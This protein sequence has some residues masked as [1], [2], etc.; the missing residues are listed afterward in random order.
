MEESSIN[1]IV[2]IKGNSMEPLINDGAITFCTVMKCYS[3][4]DIIVFKYLQD[5][6]NRIISHRIIYKEGDQYFCKGD[7]SFRIEKI[8]FDDILGKITAVLKN[9]K[10]MN[11]DMK[12]ETIKLFCDLSKRCGEEW[13]KGNVETAQALGKRCYINMLKMC[14]A[15]YKVEMNTECK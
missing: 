2:R 1:K 5:G 6:K 7:N 12:D 15:L 13:Q 14:S 4:G 9:G 11:I 8:T 3:V 10:R